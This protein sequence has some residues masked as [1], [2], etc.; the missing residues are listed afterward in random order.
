MQQ[1][2]RPILLAVNWIGGWGRFTLMLIVVVGVDIG[3]LW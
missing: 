1:L 2:T 3:S